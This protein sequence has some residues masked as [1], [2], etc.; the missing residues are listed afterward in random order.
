[1]VDG[2]YQVPA[3]GFDFGRAFGGDDDPVGVLVIVHFGG[4]LGLR[5][6]AFMAVE[7][8]VVAVA[9]RLIALGRLR[10]RQALRLLQER[11]LPVLQ[12]PQDQRLQQVHHLH[13]VHERSQRIRH[14]PKTER[15]KIVL[16][17]P[18]ALP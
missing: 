8:D 1:V 17:A 12:G 3:F 9:V 11:V 6:V 18:T 15:K 13:C 5:A 2:V 4:L 7:E 10:P 14:L 16:S